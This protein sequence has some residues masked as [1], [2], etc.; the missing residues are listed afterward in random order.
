MVIAKIGRISMARRMMVIIGLLMIIGFSIPE[1]SA[2]EYYSD[3][4]REK[5]Q[6]LY[7]C[8]DEQMSEYELTEED[9]A[10]FDT[11]EIDIAARGYT[12]EDAVE[13]NDVRKIMSMLCAEH[14]RFLSTV[15]NIGYYTNTSD[16]KRVDSID[17]KRLTIDETYASTYEELDIKI[18]EIIKDIIKPGMKELDKVFAVYMYLMKNCTPESTSGGDDKAPDT[19][20]GVLK[21]NR[22]ACG[23]FAN[24]FEWFMDKLGI[25]SEICNSRSKG[26]IWNYV[27]V[28]GEWYHLDAIS[29]AVNSSGDFFLVSEDERKQQLIQGG[30]GVIYD[31]E[32]INN[33]V[34]C[35]SDRFDE[36]YI[37]DNFS[38]NTLKGIEFNNSGYSFEYQ[39]EL[40]SI[41]SLYVINNIM[42]VPRSKET[43]EFAD[44]ASMKS[45]YTV[46][47]GGKRDF[48]AYIICRDELGNM[49]KAEKRRIIFSSGNRIVDISVSAPAGTSEISIFSWDDNMKPVANVMKISN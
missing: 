32:S 29:G 42:S 20:Y 21:E 27:N 26:H 44:I 14:P 35:S 19:V 41:P 46:I 45:A 1:V 23:G 22:G 15:N 25:D 9:R 39:G 3:E 48:N 8:L 43:G 13:W 34:I 49:L 5:L 28:D 40:F 36:G 10:Q 11:G 33:N 30:N 12:V 18:D 4:Y 47:Y 2:E 17:M 37:F 38:G 7:E 6:T 16:P 24:T 31:W